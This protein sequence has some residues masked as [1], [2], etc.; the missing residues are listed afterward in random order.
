MTSSAERIE[1]AAKAY[2]PEL[3]PDDLSDYSPM[4]R[5]Q[6]ALLRQAIIER[7]TATLQAV[8][9]FDIHE[10][11]GKFAQS[12]TGTF[13]LPA[14]AAMLEQTLVAFTYIDH[15][16][17]TAYGV[18]T[19]GE[20]LLTTWLGMADLAKHFLLQDKITGGWEVRPDENGE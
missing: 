14:D 5:G 9:D 6:L 17:K 7:M 18:R 11:Y 12:K 13:E 8:D 1:A 16:G 19:V 10:K 20:G 3:W 15:E 2:A 4:Q